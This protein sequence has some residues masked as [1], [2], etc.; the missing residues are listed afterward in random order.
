MMMVLSEAFL[1]KREK[2]KEQL[3]AFIIAV[4]REG[5]MRK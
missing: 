5:A 4:E 1:L 2:L 3:N